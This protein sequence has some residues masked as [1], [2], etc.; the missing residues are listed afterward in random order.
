MLLHFVQWFA[1]LWRPD[2]SGNIASFYQALIKLDLLPLAENLSARAYKD[3]LDEAESGNEDNSLGR[4]RLPGQVWSSWE[5][6]IA[7]GSPWKDRRGGA[8]SE[9]HSP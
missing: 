1:N 6:G 2:R 4:Q 9:A 3:L 7:H 5:F 8:S